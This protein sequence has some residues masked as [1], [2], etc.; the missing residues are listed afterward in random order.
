MEEQFEHPSRAQGSQRLLV[1]L[2]KYW[3]AS[4]HSEQVER[5]EQL[6]HWLRVQSSQRLLE[7]RKYWLASLH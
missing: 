4:L 7:L 5:E 6:M 2:R 3:L 1:E